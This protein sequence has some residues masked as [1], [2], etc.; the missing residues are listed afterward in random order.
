MIIQNR[1]SVLS[2]ALVFAAAVTATS[3]GA[4]IAVPAAIAQTS[5]DAE[6]IAAVDAWLTMAPTLT[7]L[8]NRL[9]AARGQVFV[10]LGPCPEGDYEAARVWWDAYSK[11]EASRLEWAWEDLTRV[12]DRYLTIATNTRARSPA[13]I[14]AKIR[15]YKAVLKAYEIDDDDDALLESIEADVAALSCGRA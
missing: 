12:S 11:T 1:R 7:D 6:I 3:T 4:A 8:Q 15:L 13:G 9:D 10:L 2:T 5:P 14:A